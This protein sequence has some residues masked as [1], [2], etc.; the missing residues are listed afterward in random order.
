MQSESTQNIEVSSDGVLLMCW[1]HKE[2]QM[3][4]L[5]VLDVKRTLVVCQLSE[6]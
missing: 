4:P 1:K 3:Q 6:Y 5:Q 2:K